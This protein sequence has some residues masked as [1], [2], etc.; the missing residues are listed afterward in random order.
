M[1]MPVLQLMQ[2]LFLGS[3]ADQREWVMQLHG[4]LPP[5]EQRRVFTRPPAG[6]IKVRERK[7][8]IDRECVC[9]VCTCVCVYVC[10]CE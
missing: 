4:S 1:V 8:E 3:S 10:L 7:R 2:T 6:V 5:D 9:W